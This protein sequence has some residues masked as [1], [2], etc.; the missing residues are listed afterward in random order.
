[1]INTINLVNGLLKPLSTNVNANVKLSNQD[2]EKVVVFCLAWAIGGLYEAA[3][4]AQFHEYL[5]TK[6]CPLPNKKEN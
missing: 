5:Q 3:E 4:R 1:V 6:N 2:Y